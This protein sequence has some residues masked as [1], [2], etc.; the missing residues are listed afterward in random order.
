MIVAL[1]AAVLAAGPTTY[2][3]KPNIFEPQEMSSEA[4]F[5]SV[6]V[7]VDQSLRRDS[8]QSSEDV[9][10]V[11]GCLT[12]AVRLNV[13]QKRTPPNTTD[14]QAQRCVADLKKRKPGK[15]GT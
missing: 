6:T 2:V 7:C 8:K 9:A 14:D 12:D 13:R 15:A 3:A 10:Q 1:L 5:V 11:C 4:I